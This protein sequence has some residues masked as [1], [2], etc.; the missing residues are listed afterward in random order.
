MTYGTVIIRYYGIIFIVKCSKFFLRPLHISYC[1]QVTRE[2]KCAL[3]SHTLYYFIAICARNLS[4]TNRQ[5]HPAP[6]TPFSPH[7]GSKLLWRKQHLQVA[8]TAVQQG[9]A[10][11]FTDLKNIIVK[12]FMPYRPPGRK[13]APYHINAA[14]WKIALPTVIR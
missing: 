6:A 9:P 13:L 2:K 8:E 4:V 11:F 12:I 14:I 10:I 3:L 5:T 1:R 7:V